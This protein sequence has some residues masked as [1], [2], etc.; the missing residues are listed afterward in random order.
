M[1]IIFIKKDISKVSANAIVLPA[2]ELL[3]EGLGVSKAIFAAAGKEQL[4]EACAKIGFC[5]TCE[6][7]STPAYNLKAEHIIHS[8]VPKR[9][10]SLTDEN[11]YLLCSTYTSALQLADD[12]CCRSVAIPLLGSGNNG[13]TSEDSLIVA[14]VAINGFE[15]KNLKEVIICI[16]N[17]TDTDLVLSRGYTFSDSNTDFRIMHEEAFVNKIESN[18]NIA[19]NIYVRTDDTVTHDVKYVKH[20]VGP[21]LLKSLQDKIIPMVPAK[22]SPL[23]IQIIKESETC[24][25]IKNG[26]QTHGIVKNQDGICWSN[27]CEKTECHRYEQCMSSTDAKRIERTSVIS[28]EI[29]PEIEDT[30]NLEQLGIRINGESIDYSRPIQIT[31]NEVE[32]IESDYALNEISEPEIPASKE[33]ECIG[34]PDEIIDSSISSHIILNSGPG[35][36]KTYTIVQRLIYILSNQ[37][38]AAEEIYILCYT[39][40]AKKVIVDKINDA[41]DNG[42]LPTSAQNICILTFDSYATYFLMSIKDQMEEDFTECS[43]NERIKLFNKYI[44]ADDFEPVGYFIIDEIQ[45]LVNERAQMVLNIVKNLNCGF[46]LAGDRCQAIYDY[47]AEESATIDSVEFYRQLEELLPQDIKRYEIIGNRRQCPELAAESEKLRDVLLNCKDIRKQNKNANTIIDQYKESIHIEK[48]IR[49]LSSA[50]DKSTAILCRSNG[51]AEYISSLLSQNKIP[52]DLNRGVNNQKS[53][54]KWIADV[55]WDYC[56]KDISKAEFLERVDFRTSTEYS[57]DHL[58]KLCC[59]MLHEENASSLSMGKLV[60]AF[61]LTND[62]PSEFFEKD[63]NLVVSTIHKAKGSEFDRVILINSNI[64][65]SSTSAEEARIRY[66]AI[67]RPK[68]Q[69]AVMDKNNV[70]FRKSS[71]GRPIQTKICYSYKTNNVYCSS[72]SVGFSNDILPSSFVSGNFDQVIDNQSYIINNINIHD[73]LI[74]VRS[75]SEKTFKIYHNDHH[76]GNFSLDMYEEVFWGINATNFKYNMPIE[77]SDFYVKAI[78]TQ[79]LREHNESIPDEFQNSRI[80]YGIQIGGMAKLKFN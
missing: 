75:A 45:D 2:N 73:R 29:K 31:T 72:L 49:E 50:P 71:T 46:L 44:T 19:P 78:T 76:I 61:T 63:N 20:I 53:L 24:S 60:F 13:F 14:L 3:K 42:I 7:V 36:G 67:T 39:R 34:E 12:L 48:Y 21:K 28:F 64:Q 66:V 8:V 55:F 74:A 70:F 59:N 54:A 35:T 40:S 51:E 5:N 52:H 62:L 58:W 10:H 15:S 11:E 38:C 30:V 25:Y 69:L 23:Q 37:L 9:N 43:Y 4:T 26:Q 57:G 18:I 41:I 77:L 33:Y 68:N 79:I 65:L 80:C 56:E 47:E 22:L 6:S 32:L 1:E 27:R 16:Y 17:D